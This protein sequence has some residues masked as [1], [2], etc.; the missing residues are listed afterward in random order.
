MYTKLGWIYK[1]DGDSESNSNS[2]AYAFMMW[3]K[4]KTLVEYTDVINL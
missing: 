2:L 4:H 1:G 3:L